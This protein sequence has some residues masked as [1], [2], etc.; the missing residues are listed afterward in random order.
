M[1]RPV[2]ILP[3]ALL[4]TPVIALVAALPPAL[5]LAAERANLL[6]AWFTVAS[7]LCPVFACSIVLTRAARRGLSTP[8]GGTSMPWLIGAG[9]WT[10]ASVPVTAALGAWIQTHTHHRGL[11]GATF[12]IIALGIYLGTA[13]IAWRVTTVVFSH[14]VG[15]SDRRWLAIAI[16]VLVFLLLLAA[17]YAAMAGEVGPRAPGGARMSAWLVDGALAVVGVAAATAFD[18]PPARSNDATRLGA[19]ATIF[20]VMVGIAL[21]VRSPALARQLSDRAPLASV[22]TQIIGISEV[23]RRLDGVHP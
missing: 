5:R 4:A 23:G 16:A 21:A 17:V 6:E 11:G 10:L 19:G 14:V 3:V 18:L 20:I 15:D 1:S 7:F 22:V 12:A 13:L 2:L 9:I 8:A